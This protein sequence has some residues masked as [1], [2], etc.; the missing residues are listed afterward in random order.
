MLF[1]SVF[2]TLYYIP[3]QAIVTYHGSYLPLDGQR[4]KNGHFDD[5]PWREFVHHGPTTCKHRYLHIL[6][7][8]FQFG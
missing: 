6:P 1:R 7:A 4:V 2:L 5:F 3:S 8:S